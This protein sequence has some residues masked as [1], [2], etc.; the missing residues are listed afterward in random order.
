MVIK[1][2]EVWSIDLDGACRCK[3][4]LCVPNESRLR[5]DVLDEAHKSP[6][7]VH[8]RGKKMYKNLKRNFWSKRVKREVIAYVL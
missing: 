7:T 8:P 2:L 1:E 4:R 6:M 5:I 3:G